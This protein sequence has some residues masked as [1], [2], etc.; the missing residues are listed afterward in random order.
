MKLFAAPA[1]PFARKAVV[2]LLE[3][4]LAGKVASADGAHGPQA[5]SNPAT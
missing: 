2:V 3:A 4:G 5:A 1:S